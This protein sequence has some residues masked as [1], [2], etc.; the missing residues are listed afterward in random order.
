MFCVDVARVSLAGL[1]VACDQVDV[2]SRAV[3]C[4]ER[5]APCAAVWEKVV[6]RELV[7][8]DRELVASQH[9]AGSAIHACVMHAL[10]SGGIGTN[11]RG[12][13]TPY[14]TMVR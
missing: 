11:L 1:K 7:V 5:E 9:Y 12:F 2:A 10:V 13:W 6:G 4:A 3:V 8:A 14:N